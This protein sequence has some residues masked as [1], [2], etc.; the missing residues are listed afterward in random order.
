MADQPLGMTRIGRLVSAA[1]APHPVAPMVGCTQAR[2]TSFSPAQEPLRSKEDAMEVARTACGLDVHRSNIAACLIKTA[3]SGAL[4]REHRVFSTTL[5]DLHHLGDW[6][7]ENVC[8]VVG[9][10]ATGS[11]WQ[12]VYR[13]LEGTMRVV[14]GN[15]QHIKAIRGRKTDKADAGWI[16]GKV[17][18]DGIPGSFAPQPEIRELRGIGRLHQNLV[19][20]RSRIRNEMMRLLASAGIPLSSV[21]TDLFGVSGM[22]ILRRLA[23]GATAWS[24]LHAMVRGKIRLKLDA[25]RLAL[26]S[27]LSEAQRWELKLQLERLDRIDDEIEDAE[28]ELE[29]RIHPMALREHVGAGSEP[30]TSNSAAEWMPRKRSWSSPTSWPFSCST[31]SRTANPTQTQTTTTRPAKG[32]YRHSRK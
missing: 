7:R 1:L 12:P 6:L 24:D 16:A 11:F 31:P 20:D 10:E 29:R 32:N 28:Q 22:A 13:E 17:R 9:M 27:P 3:P 18:E 21:V 8:E 30:N 15:P 4:E 2:I 25:L 14:V 26:E 23:E 19:N 5:Q